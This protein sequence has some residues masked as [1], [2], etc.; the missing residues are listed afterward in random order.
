M[1]EMHPVWP[2][3]AFMNMGYGWYGLKNYMYF[4][5]EMKYM[6]NL[7]FDYNLPFFSYVIAKEIGNILVFVLQSEMQVYPIIA[8]IIYHLLIWWLLE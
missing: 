1:D 7:S 6:I 5:F 2:L 3:N 4:V 8:Y